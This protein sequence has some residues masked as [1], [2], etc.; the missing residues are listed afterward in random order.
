MFSREGDVGAWVLLCRLNFV[1]L[2]SMMLD[3]ICICIH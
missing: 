3:I 1:K 2:K